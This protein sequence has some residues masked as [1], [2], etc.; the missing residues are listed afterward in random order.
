MSRLPKQL[1]TK[2]GEAQAAS[3]VRPVELVGVASWFGVV[4]VMLFD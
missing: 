4:T 3:K 2:M 1:S